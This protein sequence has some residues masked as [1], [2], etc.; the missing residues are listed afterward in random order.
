MYANFLP[1]FQYFKICLISHDSVTTQSF[2]NGGVDSACFLQSRLSRRLRLQRLASLQMGIFLI[3]KFRNFR[4]WEKIE[5]IFL[6]NN[7][8]RKSQNSE[9][10]KIWKIIKFGKL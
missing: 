2:E 10:H 6:K 9:N 4:I 3:T 5:T 8:I 7:K 1:L